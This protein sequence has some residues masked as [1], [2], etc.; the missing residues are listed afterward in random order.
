MK[1]IYIISSA[2]NDEIL[3]KIGVSDKVEKR[4]KE[5]K[6]GNAAT[7]SIVNQF[8]SKWAFKIEANLHHRFYSSNIRGEWFYLTSEIVADF[9]NICEKLHET[10]E[11]LSLNNTWI[12]DNSI[13]KR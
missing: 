5:L 10:F 11:F 9:T 6:T 13:L 8:E 2:I 1:K 3:Y 7:L 4:L 12:I